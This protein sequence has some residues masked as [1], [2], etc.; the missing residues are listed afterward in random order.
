MAQKLSPGA[1]TCTAAFCDDDEAATPRV[2]VSGDC[3]TGCF[4]L[5]GW[6]AVSMRLIA[7][8]FVRSDGRPP[9]LTAELLVALS[10]SLTAG[11]IA[12]TAEVAEDCRPV[13]VVGWAVGPVV[14]GATR[15]V[16]ATADVRAAGVDATA[17]ARAS[18]A[19]GAKRGV[20]VVGVTVVSSPGSRTVFGACVFCASRTAADDVVN[21]V[22][23]GVTEGVVGVRTDDVS[24][25]GDETKLESLAD[26]GVVVSEASGRTGQRCPVVTSPA[27]C[28]GG[29]SAA[30]T[31]ATG[32][33]TVRAVPACGLRV[34]ADAGPASNANANVP[35]AA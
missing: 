32:A 24:V 33:R 12:P 1:T 35:P 16:D 3:P 9:L 18:G 31:E 25:L 11:I 22:V 30:N 19:V 23:A 27:N 6:F 28:T 15:G 34:T 20:A 2:E 21:G 8:R 17:D 13:V 26:N 14:V 5:A 7:S 29:L 4:A 10:V